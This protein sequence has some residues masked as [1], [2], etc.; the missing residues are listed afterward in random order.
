MPTALPPARYDAPWKAALRH[1]FPAFMAFYFPALYAQIDWSQ[2][3]RFRDKELA[4][5][6]FG[7]APGGMVADMLVEVCLRDSA[8]RV[9]LHI[10]VQSQFDAS[11]PERMFDYSVRIFGEYRLHVASLVLLADEDPGWRPQDFHVGALGTVLGISFATAKLLDYDE[12]ELFAANNPFALVTLAHLSS[13][14]ERHD[15]DAL[16]ASKLRLTRL[17][18]E[19]G[20]SKRRIIAMFKVINWMMVLPE[21]QQARYWHAV[22]KLE[23]ERKM[24]LITPLEQWFMDKGWKKG[25]Q[26]GLEQGHEKGRMEGWREGA[27]ELLAR[28]LTQRFGPLPQAIRKRLDRASME[29]L[30]AWSDAILE[31]QSL[32]EVFE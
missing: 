32:K 19:R 11:L 14:R 23:K 15:A 2:R 13:Q 4:Q 3:P 24:E 7:D 8:E 6:G 20:W 1:A 12:G 25:V 27:A 28:Q 9:L 16:L 22:L 26:H 21:P 30:E 31:A 17:L 5:I 18:Y 10:E 29:Q